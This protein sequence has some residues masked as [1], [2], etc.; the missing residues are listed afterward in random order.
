MPTKETTIVNDMKEE[1]T[2]QSHPKTPGITKVTTRSGSKKAATAKEDNL[3][4]NDKN[5]EKKNKKKNER[6]G[7]IGADKANAKGGAPTNLTKLTSKVV[8]ANKNASTNNPTTPTQSSNNSDQR[9]RTR[10]PDTSGKIIE[11]PR[12][13]ARNYTRI[14]RQ[15]TNPSPMRLDGTDEIDKKMGDG[16]DEINDEGSM[17][18]SLQDLSL[19]PP[20]RGRQRESRASFG[21]SLRNGKFS[22]QN[23]S[24]SVGAP[25][26]G[27][28]ANTGS[29]RGR[30]SSLSNRRS[31]ASRTSIK[32]IKLTPMSKDEIAKHKANK[33]A[34]FSGDTK[35][36]GKPL[37]S[38]VR[39]SDSSSS[40][41][42]VGK[43]VKTS[44]N[45]KVGSK[46]NSSTSQVKGG[47]R[48]TSST[49]TD[50][51]YT[52]SP[53]SKQSTKKKARNSKT[54]S[55]SEEEKREEEKQPYNHVN[56]SYLDVA[57]KVSGQDLGAIGL[58]LL[59]SVLDILRKRDKTVAILHPGDVEQQLSSSEEVNGIDFSDFYYDWSFHEHDLEKG[60]QWRTSQGRSRTLRFSIKLGSDMDP[61]DLL[62]RASY[63]INKITLRGNT[64]K[65]KYKKMQE[66]ATMPGHVL[67]G[68]PANNNDESSMKSRIERA[69]DASLVSMKRNNPKFLDGKYNEVPD[70]L[71]DSDYVPN[72]PFVERDEN[73]SN[74]PPSWAKIAFQFVYKVEDKEVMHE[75]LMYWYESTR[76][77]SLCGTWSWIY[78]N[79]GT[80]ATG[81]QR[82]ELSK[83]IE[84][85][86]AVVLNMGNVVLKGLTD[87]DKECELGVLDDIDGERLPVTR[88]V[89]QIIMRLK[90]SNNVKMWMGIYLNHSG[91]WVAYYKLGRDG[92]TRQELAKALGGCPGGTIYF[93]LLKRGVAP[94]DV[95]ALLT[96]CFSVQEARNALHARTVGGVVVNR[97]EAIR[98]K[99]QERMIGDRDFDITLGMTQARKQEY[100]AA[101]AAADRSSNKA[102]V[103]AEDPDALNFDED[104]SV[105]KRHDAGSL[106]YTADHQETLG[107]T[108]FHVDNDESLSDS[109][110]DS[111]EESRVSVQFDL[112]DAVDEIE[113]GR[114]RKTN[115]SKE[116]E[117]D[118]EEEEE[119]KEEEEKEDDDM[120]E[121]SA[122][123][124]PPEFS[125]GQQVVYVAGNDGYGYATILSTEYSSLY[126]HLYRYAIKIGNIRQNQ[127]DQSDLLRLPIATFTQNEEV[128]VSL[129]N[130]R[131]VLGSVETVLGDALSPHAYG[132]KLIEAD[133]T[134]A[135]PP[136]KLRKFSRPASTR[137]SM[138]NVSLTT[139]EELLALCDP[140]KDASNA[141]NFNP[142]NNNSAVQHD[143]EA[144]TLASGT[145]TEIEQSTMQQRSDED[146]VK[147]LESAQPPSAQGESAV[148][149]S[150]VNQKDSTGREGGALSAGAGQPKG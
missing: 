42:S 89:H 2:S 137:E 62:N 13:P 106:A 146:N 111:D 121:E 68:V 120:E 94:E 15:N 122:D 92:Q 88:S 45:K 9:R 39:S 20:Q 16:K 82:N 24:S 48:S 60:W 17:N 138:P 99:Q 53:K 1:I 85:H 96:A 102:N 136:T 33:S 95:Q 101:Q 148:A 77:M 76:L 59:A 119:E 147:T 14:V 81:A 37:K 46:R 51:G 28:S 18:M 104:K 44:S 145:T 55:V 126:P 91:E 79:P 61:K 132:V 63:D 90:D 86:M 107:S 83:E 58:G 43:F 141:N 41:E 67:F 97:S 30:S 135:L 130:G 144:S 36:G 38:S 71:I 66:L 4:N 105:K 72:S 74:N 100:L 8:A 35:K 115:E 127:V 7:T 10:S 109:L 142:S 128:Q 40:Y 113:R 47:G 108:K 25:S 65:L 73:T 29:R 54:N 57:V 70:F 3:N 93:R 134:V 75:I 52:T 103:A 149:S 118:D 87:P 123:V 21:S 26:R 131:E 98:R 11:T 50:G 32:E 6:N 139:D 27:R 80:N 114:A 12:T 117:D 84:R 64:V 34:S 69:L 5:N 143:F 129:P 112:S 133:K 124:D 110:L 56:S 116:E 22:G 23:R 19:S 125:N 31:G 150:T 49:S 78:A 140:S